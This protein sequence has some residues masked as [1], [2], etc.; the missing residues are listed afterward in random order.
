MFNL[1]K[2]LFFTSTDLI[3]VATDLKLILISISSKILFSYMY[4]RFLYC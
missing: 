2:K 3:K 4:H 1:Y